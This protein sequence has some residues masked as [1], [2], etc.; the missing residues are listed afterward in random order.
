MSGRPAT[1]TVIPGKAALSVGCPPSAPPTGWRWV[2]L[3]EVAE[4]GS[5]HT[6]SRRVP[7][8][9]QGDVPWIGL[10][11]A[12]AHHGR[13]IAD[14]L[15]HVSEAGIA[16]SSARLL[17]AGT[18]C[19]SRTA[20]VGYVIV[21]G[22]DMATSQD[23]VTWTTNPSALEPRFLMWALLAEGDDIR[24]FGK[25]TTH[26]TIYFPEVKALHVCLPPLGEQRRI[27]A[28]LDTVTTHSAK[29]RAE[30]GSVPALAARYKQ[31]L[32]TAAFLGELTADWRELNP[33]SRWP[34]GAGETMTKRRKAYVEGRRGSR[35]QDAPPLMLPGEASDLPQSWAL[36]CISDTCD[37]RVG[38]AFKSEWFGMTGPRLLRGANV[39]L[40]A[41]DWADERRLDPV[42]ARDFQ[43]HVLH[44]GDIVI[45]MDRPLIA[46]GL[47]IAQVDAESD[48]A[49]LV[50]RVAN[51]RLSNL[52]HA[53]FAWWLLNSDFFRDQ[54]T[55]HSTGSDLPHVSSND[56]LTTPCPLPPHDEQQEIARRI[57]EA[58]AEIDRLAADAAAARRLLDRLDQAILAKAFR[59]ELVPQD[60]S[61]EPASALLDRIRVERQFQAPTGRGRK[62]RAA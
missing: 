41:V 48:G 8:Y 58:I 57:D 27:V 28:K 56:I 24:A 1:T 54:I 25:G 36:G 3:S 40:G 15:Q 62:A 51:P 21:M 9:W 53:R 42:R 11:D 32:L 46:G 18:V 55:Q 14:T 23:F 6:P 52:M 29:A 30:L 31:A 50:Q 33:G 44:V 17:P 12:A 47:K 43:D 16:N 5:G 26:T 10:R 59:G 2:A 13:E 45:A 37:L 60:P 49:L 35:L 38:Y 19:L 22:R 34:E 20:S 39:G 4:L 7:A 61:D